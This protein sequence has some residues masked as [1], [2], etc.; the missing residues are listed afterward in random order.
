MAAGWVTM[1]AVFHALPSIAMSTPTPPTP[2][3]HT[4]EMVIGTIFGVMYGL[5]NDDYLTGIF[6]GVVAGVVLSVLH[7]WIAVR[8]RKRGDES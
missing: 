1:E 2:I 3:N 8:R 7:T 5:K 6:V 4:A